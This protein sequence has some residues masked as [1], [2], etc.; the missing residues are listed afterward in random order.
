MGYEHEDDATFASTGETLSYRR[1]QIGKRQRFHEYFAGAEEVRAVTFSNSP[2]TLL[3]LLDE[4][5][6]DR[7]EVVAGNVEDYRDQLTD[8]PHRADRL[9]RLRREGRLVIY[10]CPNWGVHSKMYIIKHADDEWTLIDSSANL[11][12]TGWGHQTN[13]ATVFETD[14]TTV[15]DE[16]FE[17]SYLAH[18]D[19]YGV[20][21]MK[22][23][24][25][26][27]DAADEETDREQVIHNWVDGRATS[28]SEEAE[29]NEK[30]LAEAD[31]VVQHALVDDP[32]AA[33]ETLAVT[34]D[35]GTAVDTA[36]EISLQGFDGG[37]KDRL[38]A[39]SRDTD[40][41]VSKNT[42]RGTVRG[43][44]QYFERQY[45][46][47][48]MWFAEESGDLYLQTTDRDA[49]TR[50]SEPAPD[51]PDIIT[52]ELAKLEEYFQTVDEYG[53]TNAPEAVKAHL[54]EGLL[55]MF[56]AP[57]VNKYARVYREADMDLDKNL[58]Y[59]YIHGESDAG[60]GTFAEYALN[61][62]SSGAVTGGED[63]DNVGTREIKSLKRTNTVFP[64]VVD[65]IPKDT[66]HRFDTLRNMWNKNW[67][68][69]RD[70]P[71]IAF[72]S[73]DKRPKK[74][75]RNRA[76]VL[77]F[78]V[79]FP[80]TKQS[81]ADVAK[82]KRRD[83]R[84]FNWF[85]T[86]M[87]DR[88]VT[89]GDHDDTLRDARGV[90]EDLYA[91]ADRDLPAYFPREPAE[92]THSTGRRRWQNAWE[93]GMFEVAERRGQLIATFTEFDKPELY[94]Y[95]KTVPTELRADVE[96]NRIVIEAGADAFEEWLE[97]DLRHTG[98]LD[99]VS[100]FIR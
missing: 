93:D 27:I 23:L 20:E 14:G 75:F 69:D 52:G 30:L 60:K 1:E 34:G 81:E 73:N 66:I 82:L 41:S 86:L 50:L 18:R 70:F 99:R 68:G 39:L 9:E 15:M 5:G 36:F 88:E 33:D 80:S 3:K 35:G 87:L 28:K 24:S 62:I 43:V 17:K 56:W 46:I 89:L 94:R 10:T 65:D 55:W 40:L 54:F 92:R 38:E 74:W 76:K 78:D 29:L 96:G 53:E 42:L 59:L 25:E 8:Q 83:N 4:Y 26:R 61:K 37:T 32:E 67:D 47:P 58:P 95:V 64:Y 84:V 31:R 11:S 22:D 90:L 2:R 79:V 12:K 48:S 71:A 51:D 21:F 13:M 49:P 100:D 45:G 16:E 98:L 19:A 97:R 63:A 7:L 44:S 77:H 72:V 91:R 85:A 6:L 57:F